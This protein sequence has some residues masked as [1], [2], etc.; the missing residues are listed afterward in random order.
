MSACRDSRRSKKFRILT[1]CDLDGADE[2]F[3]APRSAR[4][5]P[6]ANAPPP[7]ASRRRNS[8]RVHSAD[9]STCTISLTS[10]VVTCSLHH[11][12]LGKF[13]RGVFL[14]GRFRTRRVGAGNCENNGGS[15]L[16]PAFSG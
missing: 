15:S 3:S 4:T 12:K 7:A 14:A 8:L 10:K 9:R 16:G 13:A 1:F 11:R 6:A 2:E 5:A